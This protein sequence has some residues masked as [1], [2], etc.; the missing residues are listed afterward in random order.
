MLVKKVKTGVGW[1]PVLDL[2][3]LCSRTSQGS[4]CSPGNHDTWARLSRHKA[5]I[6]IGLLQIYTVETSDPLPV[7]LPLD[8][9]G[10]RDGPYSVPWPHSNPASSSTLRSLN[11]ASRYRLYHTKELDRFR[12]VGDT[13]PAQYGSTHTW[14]HLSEFPVCKYLGQLHIDLQRWGVWASGSST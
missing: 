11:P 8:K 12:P 6:C 2:L 5:Y 10:V 14:A 9:L 7:S 3:Q 4:C 13:A 1:S